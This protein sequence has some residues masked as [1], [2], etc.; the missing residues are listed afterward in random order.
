[1]SKGKEGEGQEGREREA[2]KSSVGSSRC[3]SQ[4]LLLLPNEM[5][6]CNE[7]AFERIR[8]KSRG[9]SEKAG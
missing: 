4:R 8:D 6:E 2:A 1:M 9:A 7:I 3:A 5:D